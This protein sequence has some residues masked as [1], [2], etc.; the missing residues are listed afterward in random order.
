M[1]ADLSPV[2]LIAHWDLRVPKKP[3]WKTS[4]CDGGLL[5][6]RGRERKF[7]AKSEKGRDLELE[8]EVKIC[9]VKYS[10]KKCYG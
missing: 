3:L 9:F 6:V 5:G 4:D 8:F 10:I 2:I 1:K 7:K